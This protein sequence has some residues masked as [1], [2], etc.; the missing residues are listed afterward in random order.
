MMALGTEQWLN[1][2]H[3]MIIWQRGIQKSECPVNVILFYAG[4]SPKPISNVDSIGQQMVRQNGINLR[5]IASAISKQIHFK[6]YIIAQL[7]W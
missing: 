2:V 7:Q 4:F 6:T 5:L 1:K 3:D